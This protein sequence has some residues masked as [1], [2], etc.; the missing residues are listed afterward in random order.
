[1]T[2]QVFNR[3]G[4]PSDFQLDYHIIHRHLITFISSLQSLP[5]WKIYTGKILTSLKCLYLHDILLPFLCQKPKW[6][7][8]ISQSAKFHFFNICASLFFKKIKEML[9]KLTLM[10]TKKGQNKALKIFHYNYI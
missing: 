9:K 10:N 5:E 1:M 7:H 2:S 3:H 6:L 8:C 4:Q